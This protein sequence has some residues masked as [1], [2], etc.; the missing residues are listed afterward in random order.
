V[1]SAVGRKSGDVDAGVAAHLDDD[2]NEHDEQVD[3]AGG[4]CEVLDRCHELSRS[5]T[6]TPR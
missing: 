1:L 5:I 3:G 6:M 4:S 2:G